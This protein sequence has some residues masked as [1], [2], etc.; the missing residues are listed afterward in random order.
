MQEGRRETR[1]FQLENI[2]FGQQKLA[3]FETAGPA[4]GRFNNS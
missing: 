1:L 3:G 2:F 4:K